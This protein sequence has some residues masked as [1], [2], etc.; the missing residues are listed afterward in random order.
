MTCDRRS[1]PLTSTSVAVSESPL[2]LPSGKSWSSDAIPPG[3]STDVLE[4]DF[5]DGMLRRDLTLI[6]D[7]ERG[8]CGDTLPAAL[9]PHPDPVPPPAPPPPPPPPPPPEPCELPCPLSKLS[10]SLAPPGVLTIAALE[11]M[12]PLLLSEVADV[13]LSAT[14][15][16]VFVWASLRRLKVGHKN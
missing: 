15:L 1:G 7:P 3:S 13:L 8:I 16:R 14:D 9:L 11:S 6:P 4:A 2:S 12:V 10:L 5:C